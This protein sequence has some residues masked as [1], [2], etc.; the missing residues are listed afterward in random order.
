TLD[1]KENKA[2]NTEANLLV[3][4]ASGDAS[5]EAYERALTR[6]KAQLSW[7]QEERKRLQAELETVQRSTRG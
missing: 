7:I 3:A 6:V 2:L 1:A 5:P 4:K